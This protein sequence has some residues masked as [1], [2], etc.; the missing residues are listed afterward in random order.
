MATATLRPGA[1]R[2]S[3]W[4]LCLVGPRLA[5]ASVA[6]ADATGDPVQRGQ[7]FWLAVARDCEVPPGES[8]FDLVG[9]AIGKLGSPDPVWR[10]DIGYGVVVA[11]VY[12]KLLLSGEERRA[13][14]QRLSTN[15]A[16]G[17]GQ[18]GDDSVL[19]RSFSALDLSVLAAMELQAPVLSD[20]DYQRLL[21]DALQYLDDERDLRGFEPRVGWIHAA[22]HAADLLRFLARDPR[23][24]R[25]DQGRLLEALW[26]RMTS[27]EV[28][29]FT[30]AE[31]ERLAAAVLSLFRRTDFDTALLEPWLDRFVQLEK[32]TWAATPPRASALAASQN[33]RNLL[34][35]L[36]VLLSMPDPEP[37]GGQ[38][39]AREAVLGALRRI[40]R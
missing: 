38:L 7:S 25:A 10:D 29:V 34:T 40:R 5:L 28:P 16:T 22:A 33:A 21:N 24:S 18:A 14:V 9:E 27:A 12:R 32:D 20:S 26:V 8:A 13:L 23:F 15:L 39:A 3:L 30:H 37:V 6:D 19:L 1:L 35:S 2:L 17:I 11:C 4:L 31:D 36:Y